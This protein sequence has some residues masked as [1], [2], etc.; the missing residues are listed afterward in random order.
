MTLHLT[1]AVLRHDESIDLTYI[2]FELYTADLT[3]NTVDR[4]ST[5]LHSTMA[6]AQPPLTWQQSAEPTNPTI[7]DKLPSEVTTCLQNARFV[8]AVYLYFPNNS[9]TH[10]SQ[11]HLATCTQNTPHVSLMNYTY[12]PSHPFPTTSTTTLPPGPLIIMTSNPSSKKTHNLLANPAV[13]VL[14]HDWV[15]SRPPTHPSNPDARSASPVGTRNRSS[16]AT[17]LMS[18]NSAA[19]SSISATLNGEATVLE[20]GSAEESWCKEQHLAN[21]TFEG[22]ADAGVVQGDGNGDGGRGSYIEGDGVRVV[23]VRVRDGRVS[24]WKGRVQDFV[25][26]SGSTPLVNG[27]APAE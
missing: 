9:L 3:D 6:D 5:T 25:L 18:M 24:D 26:E 14:V 1:L 10:T 4:F 2:S 7:S 17:M 15:S 13:S 12:L 16:L 27:V 20:V 22:Q 19:V 21:N 23:V 11:L 8:R